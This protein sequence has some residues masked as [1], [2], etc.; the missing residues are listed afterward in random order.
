[1]LKRVWS[2]SIKRN[3]RK[4]RKG[5]KEEAQQETESEGEQSE[6]LIGKR[7]EEGGVGGRGKIEG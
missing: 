6:G 5:G 4:V 2:R 1:M 7:E 3:K